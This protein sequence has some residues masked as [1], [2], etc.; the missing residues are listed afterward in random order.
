MYILKT[1]FVYYD[2][3]N[4]EHNYIFYITIQSS[5]IFILIHY[6]AKEGLRFIRITKQSLVIF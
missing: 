6:L 4:L 2:Y 5:T 3:N 1:D